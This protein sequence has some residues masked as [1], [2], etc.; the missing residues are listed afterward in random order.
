[1][2]RMLTFLFV[3]LLLSQ[4]TF[5]KKVTISGVGTGSCK[6]W[7]DARTTKAQNVKLL[8]QWVL[9]YLSGNAYASERNIMKDVSPEVI[10][11]KVDRVCSAK[12]TMDINEAVNDVIRELEK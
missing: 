10:Y 3:L 2:P 12:D 5:A 8:E 7:L 11:S 9:G 6:L 4:P 1:M